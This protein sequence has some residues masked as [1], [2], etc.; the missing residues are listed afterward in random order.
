[1]IVNDV[2]HLA[3]L[4]QLLTDWRAKGEVI[5]AAEFGYWWGLLQYRNAATG[6]CNPGQ[7]EL[8]RKFGADHRTLRKMDEHAKKLGLYA[9][10]KVPGSGGNE[11]HELVWSIDRIDG[12]PLDE[13]LRVM[14]RTLRAGAHEGLVSSSNRTIEEE[15][16]EILRGQSPSPRGQGPTPVH[17]NRP[18]GED[19]DDFDPD[20]ENAKGSPAFAAWLAERDG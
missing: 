17:R 10:V 11:R 5:T 1:V 6:Q 4:G 8:E 16:K 18:P 20:R 7:R 15:K 14:T 12:V 13:N 19:E 9:V 3:K 2:V